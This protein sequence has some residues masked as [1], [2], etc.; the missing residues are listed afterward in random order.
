LLVEDFRDLLVLILNLNVRLSF[1]SFLLSLSLSCDKILGRL[2]FV[3]RP[4]LQSIDPLLESKLFIS[5]LLENVHGVL[6]DLNLRHCLHEFELYVQFLA[7]LSAI[8]TSEEQGQLVDGIF[9]GRFGIG[10]DFDFHV[11]VESSIAINEANG[12]SGK[13][14]N[15]I[16][17]LRSFWVG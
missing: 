8:G 9:V 14:L 7:E 6:V 16:R 12:C 3:I 1:S 10:L 17:E 11:L 2:L 15:Q 5:F 4:E 13:S